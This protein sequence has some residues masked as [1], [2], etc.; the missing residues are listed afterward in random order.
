[1]ATPRNGRARPSSTAASVQFWAGIEIASD[2]AIP[3][4]THPTAL[5]VRDAINAPTTAKATPPNSP[6]RMKAVS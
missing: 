4:N 3:K 2:A 1:L 6:G 5:P